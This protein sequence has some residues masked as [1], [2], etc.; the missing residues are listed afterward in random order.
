MNI[1]THWKSLL[2]KK[3]V[4][5]EKGKKPKV[6]LKSKSEKYSIGYIDIKAFEK[7]IITNY[8]DGENCRLIEE[9]DILM[10]WDGSR[11]GL[12]GQSKQGALGSTLVRIKFFGVNNHYA[13][14]F[15]KSKYLYINSNTKGAS[16]PHV[17]PNILWNCQ[18]PLAPLNEQAQIV[19]KIDTLFRNL[20][21]S[22]ENFNEAKLKLKQYRESVLVS[23]FQGKLTQDN[24]DIEE[25]NRTIE[26]F[27]EQ[28]QNIYK[29]KILEWEEDTKGWIE[30]G[31]EGKKPVKPLKLK[32]VL[33][34]NNEDITKMSNIPINWRWI[35]AGELFEFITSGSR[36][37]AKY[38]SH[39]G[40]VFVRITNLDFNS[41][42]LDLSE[43]K[44]QY[45]SPPTDSE[46]SRTKV[47]END[48]LFSITGYLGM[49]AIAQEL[50]EAYVNQH[51]ALARPLEGFN[52]HYLGYY[53]I[54]S[55][56]GVKQLQE[57]QKGGVKAGL[58][59][60]DISNFYVP[61]C[62]LEEQNQIVE[63]I[64]T[65]LNIAEKT[66]QSIDTNLAKAKAMYQSILTKA[67]KGELVDF[68]A[69]EEEFT[70]E[71][72]L[73]Q[74]QLEKITYEEEQKNKKKRKIRSKKVAKKL[75][76][77]EAL[78]EAKNSISKAEE[79][80]KNSIY[81]NDIESFYSKLKEEIE[82]NKTIVESRNA[83][84]NESYLR[85]ADA[86]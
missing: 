53:I 69:I 40:A 20:D 37:W 39:E 62:S 15:L 50:K 22:I 60:E 76:L 68:I 32:K 42:K 41:L 64:E 44:I 63:E 26:D 43:D 85:L 86:N 7:G 14:Y 2:L 31:K 80:W 11:S 59:L 8:T 70:T 73:K 52:Y 72:L 30:N 74:I 54:S 58:R 36:G 19:K 6:L 48:F 33:S 21:E 16:I 28:R 75:S 71:E 78:T 25:I 66:E 13:Y 79:L 61:L 49:F 46:G 17:D 56:G 12:V 81:S 24:T 65:R 18:F 38:Y 9:D 55:N 57:L 34:P 82:V 84:N 77:I 10:V 47:Q 45:V 83:D 29:N 51:I 4:Y 5:A 67:F 23:A 35:R 1:P 27:R 3:L